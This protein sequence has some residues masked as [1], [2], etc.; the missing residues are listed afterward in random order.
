[1]SVDDMLIAIGGSL[2]GFFLWVVFI[3]V[4]IA[5]IFLLYRGAKW[6]RQRSEEKETYGAELVLG[7]SVFPYQPGYPRSPGEPKQVAIAVDYLVDLRAELNADGFEM[8]PEF[9]RAW[10]TWARAAR[11]QQGYIVP[12]YDV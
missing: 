11:K 3:T 8:T 10:N 12:M 1:M 9:K 4:A 6:E 7:P 5:F 2:S